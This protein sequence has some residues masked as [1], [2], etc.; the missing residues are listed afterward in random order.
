MDRI[1]GFLKQGVEMGVGSLTITISDTTSGAFTF[2]AC[3]LGLFLSSLQKRNTSTPAMIPLNW[4]LGLPPDQFGLFGLGNQQAK[5]DY[6]DQSQHR[7]LI[8]SRG[9]WLLLYSGGKEE[10]ASMSGMKEIPWGISWFSSV[11]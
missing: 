10:Y 1:C 5:K 7:L 3:I 11:L 6:Y 2:C 8:S 4:K 9:N